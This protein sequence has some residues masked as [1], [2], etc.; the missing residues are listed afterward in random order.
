[1][2]EAVK[3]CLSCPS[4]LTEPAEV[5]SKFKK[6]IGAPVCGRFGHALGKPGLP[7]KQ[8]EKLAM[9]YGKNCPA[10]GE[11]LP[12]VPQEHRFQVM[13]PD[14]VVVS[15]TPD[16]DM[17]ALVKTCAS[18]RNFVRDDTVATELGWAAGLCAAKGKLILPSRQ[19]FEAKDCPSREFGSI[20]Q[21]TTGMHLLP[22]YEDAFQLNADPIKAYF[23]AK[24]AGGIPDPK[25]YPSDRPVAPDE[26]ASGIR[27]WRRVVDPEGSGNEVFLPIY[28]SSHFDAEDHAKI[29][30]AGDDEH[31]ELYVDHFG[32]VFAAAVSWTELDETP[33]L[34]GEA[35]VGKTE[36]FRHLA[37][38]MQLPFIRI[39]ITGS[40]ELD[41]LAGKMHYDPSKGT[42]F[43]YGRLPRS[44][45]KPCVLCID[46]PNVGPPDVW[47]FLRPLTDNSKQLVLD[48]NEGETMKRHTDCYLGMAMNPAFDPKNVG[49][50]Q[51]G[52]A[53]A[54]R[55]F[56][57][58]VPLPPEE[59]EREIIA[60]R[61]A[62]DG[63]EIDKGRLDGIMQISTELRGLCRE[64][65][66]PI[67][68]GVAQQIKVARALR[69]FTP[70]VAYR[71]AVADYL[72]PEAQDALLDVVRANFA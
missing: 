53:D 49:T 4:Y 63:W 20:R 70:T 45:G 2:T 42:Y 48:M 29:P 1:M 64:G 37:Y 61:V 58:W 25:D 51:I 59:L 67:T 47:Q 10:Y 54:R 46:E 7:P 26:E 35:G 3:S 34:W 14:P 57:V 19:V 22:E 60:S 38:L 24:E 52:D 72:E 65:T 33:A 18:C 71:R 56:H 21:N 11:P 50:Q 55:L 39:S 41:D 28:M 23:K 44:W 43:Q 31:P 15:R 40:T 66:L 69:W 32:G 12:P 5:V 16:P 6:S 62:L 36:L 68:W 17:Q 27:A 13:L 8:E 30:Q 9:H